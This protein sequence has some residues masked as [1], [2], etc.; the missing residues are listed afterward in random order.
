MDLIVVAF[1]VVLGAI[2]LAWLVFAERI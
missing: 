1:I 2:G